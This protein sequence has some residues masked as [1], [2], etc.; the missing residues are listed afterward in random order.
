MKNQ[1]KP[2]SDHQRYITEGFLEG[3]HERIEEIYGK[4]K[5]PLTSWIMKN[6]GTFADASDVFQDV[7]IILTDLAY[8][9]KFVLTCPMGAYLFILFRNTWMDRLK[10]KGQELKVRNSELER[11]NKGLDTQQLLDEAQREQ[12]MQQLLDRTFGQLSTTCQQLLSGIKEGLSTKA[13]TE[14]LGMSQANTFYRRKFACM[15]R[16]RS[17]VHEDPEY[18]LY[19]SPS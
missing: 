16:W 5:K 15:D 7:M 3:N 1:K 8:S 4:F 6:N 2:H 10:Q 11:F 13:L 17:L 14:K 9:P 19:L 18:R 12:K